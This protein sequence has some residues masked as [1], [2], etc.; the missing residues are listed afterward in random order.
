MEKRCVYK[1][2][3]QHIIKSSRKGKALTKRGLHM[4]LGTSWYILCKVNEFCASHTPIASYR[5]C[6]DDLE[7]LWTEEQIVEYERKVR[8]CGIQLNKSKSY[9]S[10]YHGVF[11]E[12]LVSVVFSDLKRTVA[13]S[14]SYVRIAEACTTK[15]RA[16]LVHDH[17]SGKSRLD[18]RIGLL[19]TK[20]RMLKPIK[21]VIDKFINSERG[22]DGPYW[23]GGNGTKLA[24]T[25]QNA[26]R[27]LS[28]LL[29]GKVSIRKY[30][31]VMM[32][33]ITQLISERQKVERTS[34]FHLPKSSGG[35]VNSPIVWDEMRPFVLSRLYAMGESIK[36][37]QLRATKVSSR[38]KSALMELTRWVSASGGKKATNFKELVSA[39]WLPGKIKRKLNYS[40]GHKRIY[41]VIKEK[42]SIRQIVKI[43]EKG[44][45][46][47]VMSNET[48][49]EIMDM[50]PQWKT[51]RGAVTPLP[52]N[53][54]KPE[55]SV[56]LPR[57]L[58]KHHIN[59][60]KSQ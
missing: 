12:K 7:A 35:T 4:G 50:L 51:Q 48:Y 28:I 21:S 39:S 22:R 23:M 59:L 8:L 25:E 55:E 29:T 18:T 6:G 2:T 17:F 54:S 53:V 45:V 52:F 58:K 30:E 24:D 40:L 5:I 14:V 31:G 27:V 56:Q 11:C 37:T 34:L 3:G 36:V 47:M 10:M 38:V 43:L 20:E 60:T 41:D 49:L 15:L 42:D 16:G 13:Q 33:K 1:L 9:K 46:S 26:L 57:W 32:N 44:K 19:G